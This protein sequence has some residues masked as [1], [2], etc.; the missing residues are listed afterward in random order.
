MS[1][2]SEC[3]AQVC[4]LFLI[5]ECLKTCFHFANCHVN[6]FSLFSCSLELPFTLLQLISSD[7]LRTQLI[8]FYLKA[9]SLNCLGSIGCRGVCRTLSNLYDGASCYF[10]E[11]LHHRRLIRFKYFSGLYQIIQYETGLF[12]PP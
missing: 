4:K 5:N 10:H 6:I 11:R 8:A 9:S 2:P 12:C 3:L 7:G 1:L